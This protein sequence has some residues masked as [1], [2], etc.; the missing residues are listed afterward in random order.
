M[1]TLSTKLR[2][3]ITVVVALLIVRVT[4]EVML[5]YVNYFP[6]N[7]S[8]DFLHGRDAY[9]SRYQWAFYPHIVTGPLALFVGLVLMSDRFRMR[10]PRWHRW[11]GRVHVANVVLVVLPSGFVMGFDAAAGTPAV[12][13][14]VLLTGLTAFCTT[15]GWRTAMQRRFAV[16]RRWMQRSYLLLCSA[17][18]LRILGG[19]GTVFAV[20]WLWY[21]VVIV[22]ASWVL[23]FAVFEL[24]EWRPMRRISAI[25]S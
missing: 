2:R 10:Y 17:V 12:I 6:P 24:C 4:I 19:L 23:P 13:S 1:S 16:H 18:V 9:F 22:W 14:F 11:L 7:F 5:G 8:S 3:L 21:D 15:M 25:N 20:P